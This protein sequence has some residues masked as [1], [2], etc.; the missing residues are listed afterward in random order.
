MKKIIYSIAILAITMVAGCK[1]E[2]LDINKNPNLPTSSTAELVLPN[3]LNVTAAG[4]TRNEVGAFWA[5]QWAPPTSVSGFGDERNYNTQGSWGTAS[6]IWTTYDNLTDYDFVEKDAL[7]KGRKK[8]AGIAQVMKA[9][10]YQLLVDAYGDVPYTDALKGADGLTTPKYDKAEIIYLDLIVKLD[11]AIANLSAPTT[12]ANPDVTAA[13]DIYCAGNMKKWVKFANTLKLRILLRKSELPAEQSYI[14]AQIAKI[15]NPLGG[16]AFLEAYED[17]FCNPGYLQ[18]SGKQN[19]FWNRYG[20]TEANTVSATATQ[21][22]LSEYAINAI[23]KPA[24]PRD[25]QR[26]LR[27]A[28]P[29]PA[30]P[31]VYEFIGIPFGIVGNEDYFY[32]KVS[33]FGPGLLQS[34]KQNMLIMTASE[35]LMLQ[36][37]ANVK[38][39][40]V[41]PT[42]AYKDYF[43]D[44]VRSS[45]VLLKAGA[46]PLSGSPATGQ[47]S[48]WY[49]DRLAIRESV[50]FAALSS[51]FDAPKELSISAANN[52]MGYG[53]ANPA[54]LSASNQNTLADIDSPVTPA[55]ALK[56]IMEQKWICLIGF[57]GFEAWCD[58]RKYQNV[59][60][61]ATAILD[62]PKSVSSGVTGT[63]SQRP[64]RIPYPAS[65]AQTNNKN[66]SA[67][68]SS[69]GL[70]SVSNILTTRI[71]WDKD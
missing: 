31:A 68:I 4:V 41:G 26:I 13:E 70:G 69:Q 16:G 22:A 44:A 35:S 7:A 17:V 52:Y 63:S 67:A 3:A 43:K 25:F 33:G 58:V 19:P 8:M 59:S 23:E 49:T 34:F 64:L 5:G 29:R 10:N 32:S 30:I 21:Q 65:E 38:G 9:F 66:L 53:T 50:N 62:L 27:I 11:E 6:T 47:S 1:R 71:F 18:T 56:V 39:Y 12:L 48:T 45:F 55:A 2:Y 61:G 46:N 20:F 28:K 54:P 36:A 40:L 57:A 51:T 42:G 37:E 15:T 14:S 60:G 24:G